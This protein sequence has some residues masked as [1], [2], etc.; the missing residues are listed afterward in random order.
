MEPSTVREVLFSAGE[1][2]IRI[3]QWLVSRFNLRLQ[4][5]LHSS[6]TS[7]MVD[8]APLTML[9]SAIGLCG[10]T[11]YDLVKGMLLG[12]RQLQLMETLLDLVECAARDS[13]TRAQQQCCCFFLDTL[14]RQEDLDV[15][16]PSSVNLLTPDLARMA[17]L[18]AAGLAQLNQEK[19][20]ASLKLDIS[21]HTLQEQSEG[22]FTEVNPVVLDTLCKSL[23]LSAVT[24]AQTAGSFV[25]CYEDELRPWSSR[26]LKVH[27]TLGPTMKR[28][29][30]HMNTSSQL[31]HSLELLEDSLANVQQLLSPVVKEK[32]T[33]LINRAEALFKDCRALLAEEQTS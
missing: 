2:R 25:C 10:P 8:I 27:L 33:H 30:K 15:V 12:P 3:L 31:L 14:C 29:H 18:K 5:M 1:A 32:A 24:L 13:S 20:D 17:D 7:S 11:D 22:P 21:R 28:L 16:F 4:E 23:S 6:G 26:E 9:L 19:A